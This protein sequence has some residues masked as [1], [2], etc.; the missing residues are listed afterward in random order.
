MSK[1]QVTFREWMG[2]AREVLLPISLG[3]A[4]LYGYFALW[5]HAGG[6][7][8]FA[9]IFGILGLPGLYALVVLVWGFVSAF[10]ESNR[11]DRR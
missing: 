6:S 5:R 11:H 8:G 1:D 2:W 4:F 10:L 7:W 9:L 3:I